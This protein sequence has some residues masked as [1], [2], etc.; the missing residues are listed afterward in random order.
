MAESGTSEASQLF[1]VVMRAALVVT[2]ALAS[3]LASREYTRLQNEIVLLQQRQQA[4]LLE[5][6]RLAAELLVVKTR[7]EQNAKSI[8]AL[9]KSWYKIPTT[10]QDDFP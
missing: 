4:V 10:P 7:L 1:T 6:G 9:Y 8:W 2:F 3:F 5:Q